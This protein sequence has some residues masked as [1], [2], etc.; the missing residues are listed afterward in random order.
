M[1]SGRI[2]LRGSSVRR[3]TGLVSA[4]ALVAG[5]GASPAATA[6]PLNADPS[7]G[8]EATMPWP[9]LGLPKEVTLVGANTNQDFAIPVPSGFGPTRLQGLIHAPVDFT[10]GFVEI[11]DG[12]GTVLGTV[13]LPTV[14]PDQAVVPFT[15]DL[16]AGQ[17]AADALQ[18]SFSVR[19]PAL[20]PEARC[21]LGEQV[22]LSDLAAVF[23][24]AEPAPRTI[25]SFF[26]PVLQRLTIYTPVNA[27]DAEKQATLTLASTVARMYRPQA[28]AITVATL[29]RGAAPPPAP[30][31]A[32]AV[33][34]ES[35]DAGLN[36]VNGD[37]ADVYLKLTGRGNQLSD[38]V[39]LM[40]NDV[41]SL[42]QVPGA[43]VD[44]A[45]S[46]GTAD[47]EQMT[48]GDL[49]IS[50][51]T[52]VLRTAS[53]TAGVD[54]S[55]LGSR[56]DG[57]KVHLLATHTPVASMDS[58]SV[59]VS[60]GGQAV[61]TA[62]LSSTGRVDVEFEVPA[63]FLRQRINFEFA[64]T[65]SP[66][67]LC[68]PTIAPVTFQLDPR[69]T[70]TLQRGGPALTGFSAVPSEFSPEFLVALDGSS[71]NQLDDAT[72]VV[73]KIAQRTETPLTPR[74]VDVK[75]AAQSTT[76]AL[77]VANAAT[78]SQ[79][80]LRPPVGG[81]SADIQVD[82][83]EQLRADIDRGLGSIQAFADEPRQRTVVLVTTSGA[84]SMVDP[85]FGYLDQLPDGWSTLSG[86]VLAAGPDGTVS[87]L[88]IGHGDVAAP[89]AS[90]GVNGGA[91]L[92]V[93]VG[94]AAV[95][96]ALLGVAVWRRRRRGADATRSA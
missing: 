32:R 48:F 31:F 40:A 6:E 15:V 72:R 1:R 78:I 7:T 74:V 18:L 5:L 33:V 47:A 94:A 11:N 81:E 71:P 21:G 29:P 22:M 12:R 82:L 69:S 27:D 53:F 19:E 23:S 4:V 30:Q 28:P 44:K 8:P 9:A 56:V 16:S 68:S 61:W 24:G 42:V 25:A 54:R 66:R 93:G 51:E 65:F 35:G 70:L 86:D 87:Q 90:E 36:I 10:A 57:V 73:A 76:A 26:P 79:T 60:V 91:W 59:T 95:L 77:I 38:Q 58:A 13:P 14:A 2:A 64:L 96:A 88:T 84:W 75:A 85:L 17:V 45:G 52:S 83:R 41:Q 43:R 92:A 39:S 3:I 89:V 49:N 37:R 63:E 55:A 62:P 50:G 46:T 34:V 67:Q 80:S 20:P